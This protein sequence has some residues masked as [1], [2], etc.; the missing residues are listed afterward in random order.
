MRVAVVIPRYRPVFGGAENQA[1]LLSAH[2][3]KSGIDMPFLLTKRIS[4]ELPRSQRI[5]GVPV[6][7]VG[8]PGIGRWSDYAF[9]MAVLR[10]L[11]RRRHDYDLVHCHG[12][13]LIGATVALVA[14]WT[15]RPAVVKLST[16][17]ELLGPD[18]AHAGPR[19]GAGVR[20]RVAAF[21]RRHS[22][23]VALN[24]DG[25][26]ELL[27]AAPTEP[28][29]VI[30]NGVD[31]THFRPPCPAR[32]K[33]ARDQLGVRPQEVVFAFSGRFV[34]RK[35]V[36]V[37]LDA[38]ARARARS[39]RP[40][41]LVLAGSGDLQTDSTATLVEAR[42][43]DRTSGV[44]HF[45]EP[46]DVRPAL[47]AADAFVFP[48]LREGLPNAV[49]EAMAVGLPCLLSDIPA[50]RELADANPRAAVTLTAPRDADALADAMLA[51]ASGPHPAAAAGGDR[52]C[53]LADAFRIE[54]VA[55]AYRRL[56]SRLA[57]KA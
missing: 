15:G 3:L 33:A 4:R 13:A 46:A 39:P 51:F 22:H 10:F 9:C 40:L 27:T 29:S 25:E 17:G 52:D 11:L 30:P 14:K 55:D 43:A 31:T 6:R 5:D 38:F 50:H 45:E 8:V 2:L 56:Y 21:A 57:V 26:R 49:L 16:L 23:M 24:R 7:R 54:R 28:Y 32:R 48:S 1:A 19:P 37:L 12:S 44:L 34:R 20:A 18:F 42:L 41:R 35:G 53:V 36:D 47:H